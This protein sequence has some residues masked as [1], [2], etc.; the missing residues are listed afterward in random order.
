MTVDTVHRPEVPVPPVK[1]SPL[2]RIENQSRDRGRAV[3]TPERVS[4]QR[5][6]KP[7]FVVLVRVGSGKK[8]GRHRASL[9]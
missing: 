5:P 8:S 6:P 7:F 9:T 4:R 2:S 1:P 3:S